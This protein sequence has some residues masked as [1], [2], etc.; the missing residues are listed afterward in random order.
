VA[1]A[2]FHGLPLGVEF[3]RLDGPA[4]HGLWFLAR[5]PPAFHAARLVYAADHLVARYSTTVAG[6]PPLRPD[7]ST[8]ARTG[9]RFPVGGHH[10]K[11]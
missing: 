2:R 9:P 11:A 8:D 6:L 5:H 7:H 3:D 10:A 1:E 4:A